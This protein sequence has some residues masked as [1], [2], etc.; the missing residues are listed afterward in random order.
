MFYIAKKCLN[1]W[2]KNMFINPAFAQATTTAAGSSSMTGMI[3]QLL[4]I[5]AIFYILLIRPQQKRMKE[6]EATLNAIKKG[7]TILTG[8][9]VYGKVVSANI[10]QNELQVELAK[11]VVVKVAL[12]TVRD[13]VKDEVKPANNNKKSKK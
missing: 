1:F 8:G 5:F 3:V 6:H 10:E 4:L 7:D 2:R 13:V 9:G 12:A 11:D